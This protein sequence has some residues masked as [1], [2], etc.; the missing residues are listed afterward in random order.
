MKR[1]IPTKARLRRDRKHAAKHVERGKRA[2]RLRLRVR[3]SAFAP[4]LAAAF[5]FLTT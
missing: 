1:P 4:T 3:R 5:T 2:K